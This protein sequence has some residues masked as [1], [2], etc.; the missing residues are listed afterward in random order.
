MF[1]RCHSNGGYLLEPYLVVQPHI[2][3]GVDEVTILRGEVVIMN[4]KQTDSKNSDW[5]RVSVPR[6]QSFGLV[7]LSVTQPL[8][9]EPD[10][11]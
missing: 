6:T 9:F 11:T 3:G 1:Q 2:A 5:A 8:A 7:P 10:P 4:C